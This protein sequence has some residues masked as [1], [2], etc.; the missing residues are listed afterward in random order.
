VTWGS[1]V[2]GNVR[3][4]G[5]NVIKIPPEQ[6]VRTFL[7]CNTLKKRENEQHQDCILDAKPNDTEQST[8]EPRVASQSNISSFTLLLKMLCWH[9]GMKRYHFRQRHCDSGMIMKLRSMA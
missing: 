5:V 9:S 4:G 2:A 7:S 1:A 3:N 6:S 8:S